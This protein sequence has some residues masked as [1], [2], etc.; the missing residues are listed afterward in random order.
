MN[1]VSLDS[2]RL[3]LV[4]DAVTWDVFVSSQNG[5]LL[6]SYAWGALK[7][8]F[9][10]K[11]ERWAWV[12]GGRI[13]M[14][15]QVL[16]RRLMPSLRIAYVPRGP[17]SADA[18]FL[19]VMIERLR[20]NGVFLITLEPN[21]AHGDPCDALL[22]EAGFRSS[23]E[24]IQP[25]ATIRIDLTRSAE[26]ILAAMKPKWRYNIRLS[27][28]KGVVVREGAA[29]DLRRF[30]D[31]IQITARRDRFA[32]H[33]LAYY[34]NAFELLSTSDSARLLAAEYNGQ[35]LA[36]ILVTAFGCEAIYLYGASGNDHR[37]VMPNHALHWAAIQW[38]K[39]RG[40]KWYD[41][42]GV[43]EGGGEAGEARTESVDP[44]GADSA[45][46]EG[47]PESRGS[48]LPDSLAQFKMGF[49]GQVVRY[50]G[51][52]DLIFSPTRYGIYR[53]ARRVRRVAAG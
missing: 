33:P 37:N 36:M 34:R 39:S 17:V 1:D 41:L 7:S 24:T 20:R 49:G 12:E 11:A 31:L 14:A 25:P 52:W 26:E 28:R 44:R 29:S 30:F 42:W 23:H 15:A 13:R 48:L 16:S 18:S 35:V 9:G 27:E 10:W 53:L 19:K 51:A 45:A 3:S 21:W 47:E 32:V 8:R 38:A 5:H 46:A 6:Q 22:S 43:P 2:P 4:E 40:C 50:T